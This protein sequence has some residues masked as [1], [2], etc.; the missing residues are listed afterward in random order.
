MVCLPKSLQVPLGI[1]EKWNENHSIIRRPAP[2]RAPI[3]L[4]NKE[5][6]EVDSGQLSVSLVNL[7]I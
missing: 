1:T 5:V 6:D 2:G 4:L 7:Y 3:T